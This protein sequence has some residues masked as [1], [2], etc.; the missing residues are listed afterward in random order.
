MIRRTGTALVAAAVFPLL[1]AASASADDEPPYVLA[2]WEAPGGAETRFAVPQVLVASTPTSSPD[3]SQLDEWLACGTT[4]QVDLYVN[5]ETTGRLLAGG[6]LYG[7]SNPAESWP[8]GSRAAGDF[9]RRLTTAACPA[10]ESPVLEEPGGG[11]VPATGTQPIVEP[12][13]EGQVPALSPAPAAAPVATEPAY[14][15]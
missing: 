1:S 4:Y 10:E 12:V 9:S 15:G 2:L 5:D 7:P 13:P 11:E 6:V 8:G 14:T 3:L